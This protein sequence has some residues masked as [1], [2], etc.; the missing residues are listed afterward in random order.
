MASS[1]HQQIA[2]LAF[3]DEAAGRAFDR[4]RKTD[5]RFAATSVRRRAQV[6]RRD[7]RALAAR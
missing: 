6:V 2:D 3:Q 5:A 7:E 4:C 1:T